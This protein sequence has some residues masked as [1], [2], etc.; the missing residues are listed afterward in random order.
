MDT[1]QNVQT[2][3]ETFENEVNVELLQTI[4]IFMDDLAN[5]TKNKNFVDFHTIV[6]RIDE[7]KV[8]SY[9]TL[10]SGFKVFFNTNKD[11]MAANDF[12][13]LIDPTISYVSNNGTFSF[14]FYN[15]FQEAELADQEVIKDHLNLIW[16]LFENKEE[17]Y[18]N[19]VIQ[20]MHCT[21]SINFDIIKMCTEFKSKNLNLSRF[22]KAACKFI[23]KRLVLEPNENVSDMLS[24]VE[25]IDVDNFGIAEVFELANTL[26][27]SQ[28]ISNLFFNPS[29]S[30]QFTENNISVGS[31]HKEIV[32]LALTEDNVKE[33]TDEDE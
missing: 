8:K 20:N 16:N 26:N 9:L 12:E 1:K 27:L 33:D 4:Q 18:L 29:Q 14:D 21:D 13:N 30:V 24:K 23:R 10:V 32:N 11:V 15:A 3:T 7:S 31:L 19:D 17:K 2:I 28:V 5:I 22:I 25:N 6:K